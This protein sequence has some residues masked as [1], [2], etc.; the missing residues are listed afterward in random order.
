MPQSE[1][2]AYPRT[3][4]Q[5]YAINVERPSLQACQRMYVRPWTFDIGLGTLHFDE[6]RIRVPSGYSA[7]NPYLRTLVLSYALVECLGSQLCQAS[8]PRF[9]VSPMPR[10]QRSCGP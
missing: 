4:V 3:N 10:G 5:S 6:F 8:F 2:I 7:F 9:P 1:F